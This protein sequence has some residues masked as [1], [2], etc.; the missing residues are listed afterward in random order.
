MHS[1]YQAEVVKGL[2]IIWLFAAGRVTLHVWPLVHRSRATA[3]VRLLTSRAD[4]SRNRNV[5]G[6]W[7]DEGMTQN[8]T[9]TEVSGEPSILASLLGLRLS[10]TLRLVAWLVALTGASL[11]GLSISRGSP[12]VA[13]VIGTIVLA[14]GLALVYFAHRMRQPHERA[15]VVGSRKAA[16]R[17]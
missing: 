3:R 14:L 6:G 8:E 12:T 5:S 17:S 10:Q 13:V 15:V 16:V 9:S 2:G 11:L 1:L 7:E 4:R